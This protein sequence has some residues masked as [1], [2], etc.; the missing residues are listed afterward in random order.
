MP[1]TKSQSNSTAKPTTEDAVAALRHATK[2]KNIPPAGLEA[3]GRIEDRPKVRFGYNPH[4][5]PALR[6]APKAG[7]TDDLVVCCA[8]RWPARWATRRSGGYWTRRR[9]DR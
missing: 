3:Q 9:S 1:R 6:S 7:E 8:A 5:P 4:L 2:R